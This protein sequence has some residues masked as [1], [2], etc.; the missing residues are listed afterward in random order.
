MPA[1]VPALPALLWVVNV[2]S[3]DP[4]LVPL[5]QTT[6]GVVNRVISDAQIMLVGISADMT[7]SGG[8]GGGTQPA[9]FDAAELSLEFL[10][11]DYRAELAY[12][13][14]RVLNDPWALF[15]QPFVHRGEYEC[16][17][18]TCEFTCSA[19]PP[20]QHQHLPPWLLPLTR[21]PLL[22]VL[23]LQPCRT[24]CSMEP[25]THRRRCMPR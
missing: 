12:G 17:E 9:G 14:S 13:K 1:L 25:V 21:Q 22:L 20:L 4:S 19:A 11:A 10:R 2:S 5:F 24:S 23:L 15:Q 16:I 18:F 8:S 7:K 3:L 6:Q